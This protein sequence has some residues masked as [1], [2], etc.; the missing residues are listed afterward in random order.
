[1][2]QE[3]VAKLMTKT[4]KVT[5]KPITE[6]TAKNYVRYVV[7]LHKSVH[8]DKVMKSMAW[9]KAWHTIEPPLQTYALST[10]V[11]ILN[12]VCAVL[13]LYPSYKAVVRQ[14][15]VRMADRKVAAGKE[16]NEGEKN[17]KQEE[18]W[19]PWSDV[20]A[21]RDSLPEGLDKVLLSLYTMMPPGRAEE[22]ASME[23]NGGVNSYNT[24]T[25]EMRITKH[26]T[27]T[28]AGDR[29]V[30]VPNDLKAV[31][32]KWLDGRVSG[33]LLGVPSPG[34]I[35]KR[36]NKVFAPKKI[37]VSALRH[38]YDSHFHGDA[39]RSLTADAK[40]MGHSR[41][42]AMKTYVK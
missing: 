20:I 6:S 22:Y 5:G 40:A 35:T 25:G 15:E 39:V 42:T 10:Q 8:K 14:Y 26:K 12:A 36:L 17:T 11:S 7:N 18:Y 4:S 31:L 1:M 37:S 28:S 27:M 3:L 29:V 33:S 23:V 16:E 19:M 32:T 34:A 24:K 38:L 2:E 13:R 21:K 41:G 30:V 9:L